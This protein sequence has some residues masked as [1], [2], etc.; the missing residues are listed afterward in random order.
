MLSR[1]TFA[2]YLTAL[3]TYK[4]VSFAFGSLLVRLAA[5]CAPTDIAEMVAVGVSSFRNVRNMEGVVGFVPLQYFQS[6]IKST[7][8]G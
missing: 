3:P 1:H 4:S 6:V 7:G 5:C 2:A 8:T